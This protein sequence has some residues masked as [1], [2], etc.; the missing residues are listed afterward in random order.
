MVEK[1]THRSSSSSVNCDRWPQNNWSRKMIWM[2]WQVFAVSSYK[3]S[4]K[5]NIGWASTSKSSATPSPGVGCNGV[6]HAVIR[7]QSSGVLWNDH[8]CSSVW[9]LDG[10]VWLGNW[11]VWFCNFVSGFGVGPLVPSERNRSFQTDRG[12]GGAH[13]YHGTARR[14]IALLRGAS[15]VAKWPRAHQEVFFQSG[16]LLLGWPYVPFTRTCPL[17]TSCPFRGSSINSRKWPGFTWLGF[18]RCTHSL[19]SLCTGCRV[20]RVALQC[21]LS[22]RGLGWTTEQSRHRIRP[23]NHPNPHP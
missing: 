9:K 18:T 19:Y 17:F 5:Q 23:S 20:C 6:K 13:P 11:Q 21:A 3:L 8:S 2:G 12:K 14:S 16:A 10:Q 4:D 15:Q 22:E 7:L 1:V